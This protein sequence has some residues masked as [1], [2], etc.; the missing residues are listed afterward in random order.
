MYIQLVY[1]NS[2]WS[3]YNYYKHMYSLW[4]W[5][6]GDY[7]NSLPLV[8]EDTS[9]RDTRDTKALCNSRVYLE[10]SYKLV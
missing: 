3:F 5:L 1:Y 7:V 6:D 10:D 9:V 4:I 2:N 8:N